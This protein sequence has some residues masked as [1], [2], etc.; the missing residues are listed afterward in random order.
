MSQILIELDSTNEAALQEA[1]KAVAQYVTL[2]RTQRFD[3]AP[4]VQILATLNPVTIPPLA[5]IVVERVQANRHVVI[6]KEGLTNS[7]LST[8]NAT[9]VLTELSKND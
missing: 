5:R 6:K 9:K 2:V 4:V 1:L 8:D 7:G 3:G